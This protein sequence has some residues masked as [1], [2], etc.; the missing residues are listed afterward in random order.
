MA[1]RFDYATKF[2][3]KIAAEMR[4][5]LPITEGGEIDYAFIETFIRGTMKLAIGG[6]IA[7]KDKEIAATKTVIGRR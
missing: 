4:V 1:R 3:R 5:P 2:T 7:W 6:V